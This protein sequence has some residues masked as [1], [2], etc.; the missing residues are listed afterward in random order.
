MRQMPIIF[1]IHPSHIP[2]FHSSQDPPTTKPR[3]SYLK[4]AQQGTAD[5]RG[6]NRGGTEGAQQAWSLPE[7]SKGAPGRGGDTKGWLEE[8]LLISF[9]STLCHYQVVSALGSPTLV[10]KRG[11][12]TFAPTLTDKV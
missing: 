1:L 6:R 7:A 9:S 5:S 12:Q 3:G 11:L 4:V 2:L 8:F 10:L